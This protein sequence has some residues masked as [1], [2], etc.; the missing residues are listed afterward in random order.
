MVIYA[1]VLLAVVGYA[2]LGLVFAGACVEWFEWDDGGFCVFWYWLVWPALL[3]YVA[4]VKSLAIFW[5]LVLERPVA[6]LYSLPRRLSERREKDDRL[7]QAKARRGPRRG[8][9]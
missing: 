2:A 7:P 6:W 9:E 4:I 5:E 3:L 8:D 1:I